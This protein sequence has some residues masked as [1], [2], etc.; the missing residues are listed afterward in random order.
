MRPIY[1][2]WNRI[3]PPRFC[4]QLSRKFD[5]WAL[6]VTISEQQQNDSVEDDVKHAVIPGSHPTLDTPPDGF[7]RA[8][9]LF[10]TEVEYSSVAKVRSDWVVN[11]VLRVI[12]D[13]FDE[14]LFV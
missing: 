12:R 3:E 4:I 11:S 10:P 1:E 14:M 9:H 8:L 6:F 13:R 7:V 5:D 2:T